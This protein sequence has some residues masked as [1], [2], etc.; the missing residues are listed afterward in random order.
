LS[1]L[2]NYNNAFTKQITEP[3]TTLTNECLLPP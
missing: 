1:Q 3:E 2:V